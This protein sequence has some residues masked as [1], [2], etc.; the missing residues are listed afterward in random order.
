MSTMK[1]AAERL[2]K[3]RVAFDLADQLQGG[4]SRESLGA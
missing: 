2:I 1:E 4:N 3:A